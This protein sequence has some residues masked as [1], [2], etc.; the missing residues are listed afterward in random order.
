[1]LAISR[2]LASAAFMIT[3]AT[4]SVSI[5]FFVAMFALR[6]KVFG[7]SFLR[8]L[9]CQFRSPIPRLALRLGKCKVVVILL[10]ERA[11]K[12]ASFS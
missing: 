7:F 2:F 8:K 3:I 11:R 4:H 6:Y 10:Y 9:D 5:I 1:M 12:L